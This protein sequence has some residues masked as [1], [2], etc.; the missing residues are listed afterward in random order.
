M[1][2]ITEQILDAA[3]EF[4]KE[5]ADTLFEANPLLES[6]S[7]IQGYGEDHTEIFAEEFLINEESYHSVNRE[8][9]LGI[10]NQLRW[11]FD[12][13]EPTHLMALYGKNMKIKVTR[14]EIEITSVE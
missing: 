7:W 11:A 1:D 14:D 3:G 8:W 6:F 10:C 12:T 4:V 13:L 5:T 9:Q 2:Y